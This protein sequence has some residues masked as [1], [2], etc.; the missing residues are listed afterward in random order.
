MPAST[1]K[2]MQNRLEILKLL[3]DFWLVL[4]KEHLP[5]ARTL[6]FR[7]REPSVLFILS[8]TTK[9]SN[10]RDRTEGR[11][12]LMPQ[13]EHP[14]TI[15]NRGVCI[16]ITR[17][18]LNII[19]GATAH[20]LSNILEVYCD[21]AVGN[22]PI[23]IRREEHLAAHMLLHSQPTGIAKI[24]YCKSKALEL[25]ALL[26]SQLSAGCRDMLSVPI[27]HLDRE[28]LNKAYAC[29]SD[30]LSEPPRLAQ[31]A[32]I[33]GISETKLKRLFKKRYGLTPYGLVQT[34]RMAAAHEMISLHGHSV[35]EAAYA[36]GYC[37][38]SHFIDAFAKQYGFKP[39]QLRACV[40]V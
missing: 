36:V 29:L 21:A 5:Q 11:M 7:V 8:F 39:G 35:S 10:T 6:L 23:P 38:V 18:R 19:L 4:A 3:D 1:P 33:V 13:G 28:A 16:C 32:K 34:Q 22:Y 30:N 9:G 37:N 26:M 31:V 27:S 40:A 20:D 17:T 15:T 24:L 14:L 25:M 12:T 2:N